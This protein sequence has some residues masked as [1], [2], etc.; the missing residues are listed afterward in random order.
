MYLFF[1]INIIAN[2]LSVEFNNLFAFT[3]TMTKTSV[4]WFRH[5]LRLH[6]NPALLESVKDCEK[7]Y[8][9]FIH[10]GETAGI[11]YCL[12][13]LITYMILHSSLS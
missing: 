12:Y 8:A 6:D 9:I 7:F 4:H 11:V 3:A 10:D 13:V 2:Y 1:C 5:G